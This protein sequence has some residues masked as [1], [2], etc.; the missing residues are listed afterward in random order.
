MNKE[1]S[2][3]S[4]SPSQR[5]ESKLLNSQAVKLNKVYANIEPTEPEIN[6]YDNYVS[7][8]LWT[9]PF[10]NPVLE[11]STWNLEK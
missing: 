8:G 7:I 4:L 11:K 2:V 6:F 10:E 9:N 5:R 1:K 3:T